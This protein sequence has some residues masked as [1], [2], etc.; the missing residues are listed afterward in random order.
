M[1]KIE[2]DHH[3]DLEVFAWCT[4][5]FGGPNIPP[6]N[7]CNYGRGWYYDVNIE[8]MDSDYQLGARVVKSIVFDREQDAVL[9]ALKWAA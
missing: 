4:E 7:N 8:I 2:F 9:F 1:H 3:N 6:S 5:Q